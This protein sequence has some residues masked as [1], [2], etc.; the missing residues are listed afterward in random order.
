MKRQ[1]YLGVT[2]FL[3]FAL[4]AISRASAADF[5]APQP[6]SADYAT[7][8]HGGEKMTG[9]WYFAPP[10]IRIEV[11]SSSQKVEKGP[12]GGK[13]I[14]IID[15]NTQT[16]DMLMPQAHMYMEIHGNSTHM[17]SGMRNLQNLSRG[18]CPNGATC[19]KIG[20]DAVNGRS[21]DKYDMTDQ[22]GRKST[23]CVDQ[24]LNFPI[25]LQE[26]DGTVSEFTNIKEGAPDS[27]LFKV[28]DGYRAFDPS[29]F[30]HGRQ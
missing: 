3:L 11:M 8:S 28:P 29:V 14:M 15:S 2:F 27:S 25:R 21:C 4:A 12:F 10:K 13:M 20:S 24:K 18:A 19:K 26:E 5:G 22:S 9:K 23:V 7:T 17:D 16:S 1:K 30:A 6:F